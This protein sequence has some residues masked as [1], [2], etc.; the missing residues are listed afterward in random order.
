MAKVSKPFRLSLIRSLWGVIK[1]ADG[2]LT[3]EQAIP[4]IKALGYDGVETGVKIAMDL[5]PKHFKR[6]LDDNGLK[7]VA[8]VF[9]SGPAV[10]VPGADGDR[11][12]N[13]PKPGR[14]VAEHID[15]FKAQ[16]DEAL[17]LDPIKINSHSGNDYFFRK[18]QEEFFTKALDWE[19]KNSKGVPIY[20][21]THRK[22]ILHSPWVARELVPLFKGDLKIVAD[23]SHFLCVAETNTEDKELNAVVDM[24]APYTR[25]IHA[26]V[27]YDHGPQVPDPRVPHWKDYVTGMLRWWTT[28]MQAQQKAGVEVATVTPEH[29]PPNYQV[30][31]PRWQSPLADIWEV[32]T[33]VGKTVQQRFDETFNAQK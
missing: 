3:F 29:G 28:I 6:V 21:E 5:G 16:V 15:V 14:S 22:R 24:L 7:Y 1:Q 25:H 17:Q 11:Y 18:E 33:W 10:V 9:T 32:N 13:H 31:E 19:K 27:G 2:H 23:L 12:P 8:M 26:R 30:C 20:H 4:R